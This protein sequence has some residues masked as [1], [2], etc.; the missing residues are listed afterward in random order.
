MSYGNKHKYVCSK[1]DEETY[2]YTR[3]EGRKHDCGGIWREPG[4]HENRIA[5]RMIDDFPIPLQR[6]EQGTRER[7]ISNIE[8]HNHLLERGL[9]GEDLSGDGYYIPDEWEESG[10]SFVAFKFRDKHSSAHKKCVVFESENPDF[11]EGIAKQTG[12]L[13]ADMGIN[14]D[15]ECGDPPEP[16][17]Y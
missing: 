1:C 5:V 4:S 6:G 8:I 12:D 16:D 7:E 13:E 10:T 15:E 3:K 17:I 14:V 2:F 9:T 11:I